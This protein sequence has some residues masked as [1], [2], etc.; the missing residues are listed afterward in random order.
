MANKGKA[1]GSRKIK[2]L[3]ASPEVMPFAGTGGLGEV[4]GSLP[5][6]L[7]KMRSP[8]VDCRVMM[9]LYGTVA[10][11]HREKMKFLGHMDVPVGWRSQYMGLFELR[12]DGVIYYFVD[13][14]YYFKR[15][16][17]YGHL[18][19]CER[20]SFFS[21][22]VMESHKITGF[23]PDI[24]HANDWQTAL[25]PVFGKTIYKDEGL[26][27]VFTVH[28]IEYQG[29]Y[30]LEVLKE[31]IGL[32]SDDDYILEMDGDV[33][34]MKG[35]IDSADRFTTVS[36]TYASELMDPVS[37]FGLHE[38]V[39]RNSWRMEGILNGINTVTYDPMNDPH[40]AA[41]YTSDRMPGK[42]KCKRAL[43][44][45]LG[46]PES[47]APMLTMIT[48]LVAPK[49]VDIVAEMMD[50]LLYNND[51]QFVMLGTGDGNYE[52]YFRELQNRH[53][54]Q[55]ISMIEFD[56]GK[57]HRVY[58]AGDIFLMPSRSEP[59][60]LSQMIACRYGNVPIVRLTGGLADSI[61]EWDGENG[62]GFTFYDYSRGELEYAVHRAMDLYSHRNKW[63]KLVKHI[64]DVDFSWERSAAE[65][66]SM[67]QELV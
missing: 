13:N 31:C 19:D 26:K 1:A 65:Y 56:T 15:D 47:D 66:R 54:D 10:Q 60:G 11:E 40:I 36:P 39:R 23:R 44:N 46:L 51:M 20:F 34:L 17:L 2:I 4:A 61:S 52:A 43:Q 45:E 53:P 32:A 6:A 33:N 30:G 49:G 41:K 12:K 67:Y 64:I 16:S 14:E 9:P 27:T 5:R 62:N 50:D 48:R 35:A 18:D 28:N 42:K 3:M 25:I 37:A 63:R 22:A 58:A 29:R 55:V 21:R 7:N 57:A 59:C 38:I 8:G 24:I